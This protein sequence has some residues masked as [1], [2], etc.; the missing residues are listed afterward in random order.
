MT[1]AYCKNN[2]EKQLANMQKKVDQI[3]KQISQD[4][5]NKNLQTLLNENK[6]KIDKAC[7]S[8]VA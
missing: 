8:Q 6:I 5:T 1:I 2:Q 4:L 3:S 7:S